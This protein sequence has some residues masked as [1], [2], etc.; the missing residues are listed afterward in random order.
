MT[1]M[2]SSESESVH[3]TTQMIQED[4]FQK[5]MEQLQRIQEECEE[6]RKRQNS[7]EGR[8][9]QREE[10]R[11]LM[12]QGRN[13]VMEAKS[14]RHTI[15]RMLAEVQEVVNGIQAVMSKLQETKDERSEER[16][17]QA[18]LQTVSREQVKYKASRLHLNQ[19]NRGV[20]E[21]ETEL[22]R[23]WKPVEQTKPRSMRGSEVTKEEKFTMLRRSKEVV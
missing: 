4:K 19:D 13:D 1:E 8:A 22:T 23:K 3:S 15:E 14:M 6:I 21:P 2:S 7:M 11:Q 16:Q 20:N 9:L 18:N 17:S 12:E 10:M 5:V